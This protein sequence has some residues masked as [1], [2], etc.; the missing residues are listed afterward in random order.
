[1]I[2]RCLIGDWLVAR[3][4]RIPAS[5]E[6]QGQ[7]WVIKSF[8]IASE[9]FPIAHIRWTTFLPGFA[10][11]AAGW[12]VFEEDNRIHKRRVTLSEAAVIRKIK[13]HLCS[14]EPWRA[15]AAA[16]HKDGECEGDFFLFFFC[17]LQIPQNMF[18]LFSRVSA[19]C[20]ERLSSESKPD[21]QTYMQM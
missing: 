20:T 3:A 9:F 17:P 7:E 21:K 19:E 11:H 2:H 14:D 18:V 8:V 13:S 12:A 16:A 15:A 10:Q 1:M 5:V 6:Q 4:P